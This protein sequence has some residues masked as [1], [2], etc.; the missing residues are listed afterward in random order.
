MTM[1]ARE[2]ERTQGYGLDRDD[3]RNDQAGHKKARQ[4]GEKPIVHVRMPFP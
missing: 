4:G 3:V 2:K 1:A